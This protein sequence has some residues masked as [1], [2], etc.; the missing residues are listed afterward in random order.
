MAI[1]SPATTIHGDGPVNILSDDVRQLYDDTCAIKSQ[2]LILQDFGINISE[3]QL[4]HEALVNGWYNNGTSPADVG[5]LLELHGVGVSQYDNANIFNLVNELAQG[6][7][8]IVGVDAGELW[9]NSLWDRLFEDS[10]ADHA[11]IVSGVDTSDPNNVKV[12]LTDPGTGDLLKEYPMDQFVDAW[13]DSNCFMM[14]T[15]DAVPDIFNPF[16][17]FPGFDM[18]INNL[19][20]IG[21]MPYDM[22]YND[23]AF[24]NYTNDI[25]YC[26]YDDFSA[27]VGGD[28]QMFSPES[29]GFFDEFSCWNGF[30]MM[31]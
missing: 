3:D 15:N 19:P 5:K 28:I 25:P 24:L 31:G 2:Q 30:E 26:V 6:H 12:I 29:I 20:M 18:P 11:L 8:V 21:Q 17:D 23:L 7:K 14:T 4:R 16:N 1:Y 9:E 22:F 10:Q 27:Y 13:Q